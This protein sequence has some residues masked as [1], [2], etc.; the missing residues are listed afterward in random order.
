MKTSDIAE[1]RDEIRVFEDRAHA[2]TMLADM[3]DD[4]VGDDPLILGVAA[5]GVA[6]GAPVAQ[7]LGVGLS[8]AVV[9]KI[10]PPW[11]SEWG[12]GAVAY[13]GLTVIDESSLALAGIDRIELG[14]CTQ[15]ARATVNRRLELL[16]PHLPPADLSGRSVV[17]VDDGL[18]TGITM[19]GAIGAVERSGAGEIVM[20]VPTAHS[21]SI[22]WFA[23]RGG[24]AAIYCPNIRSAPS[25]A[26]A[27]AYRNWT[28]MTDV[29][30]Q[31]ILA[32]FTVS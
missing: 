21:E 26:V 23:K 10:T 4:Q 13:D 30:I 14:Q 29:E 2:G 1:L 9:N 31:T 19:R 11:H 16:A 20:A 24:V 5:G 17:L 8:V 27:Q 15:R 12:F 25:F 28:N 3:L 22:D 18:A 7:R 6:V 32:G